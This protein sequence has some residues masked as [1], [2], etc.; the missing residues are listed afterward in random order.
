MSRK[1]CHKDHS[2]K[3]PKSGE[4]SCWNGLWN[5]VTVSVLKHTLID[6]EK[7]LNVD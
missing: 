7:T 1:N 3:D 4:K 5:F 6:K 2:N